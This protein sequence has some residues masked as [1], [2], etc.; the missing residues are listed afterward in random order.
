MELEAF[1]YQF[2]FTKKL[3]LTHETFKL[4]EL[5]QWSLRKRDQRIYGRMIYILYKM[6]ENYC[7]NSSYLRGKNFL[8]LFCYHQVI[9]SESY[10]LYIS[11]SQQNI[12]QKK[13]KYFMGKI[14]SYSTR[15]K[16]NILV[17]LHI[18]GTRDIFLL[19]CVHQ[20]TDSD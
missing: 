18:P 13:L 8:L 16:K 17:V 7:G 15:R 3:D 20:D 6:G 10:E 5:D 14:C 4:V 1:T 11:I 12:H 2:V 19:F 9:E